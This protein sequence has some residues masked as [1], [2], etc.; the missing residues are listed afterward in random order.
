MQSFAAFE[1]LPLIP[2]PASGRL[3]PGELRLGA[4]CPI[5]SAAELTDLG[6]DLRDRLSQ[7]EG[8]GD[9]DGFIRLCLRPARNDSES[10][11]S[12]ELSVLPEGVEV[13][14]PSR[15]GIF[16][17]LQTLLQLIDASTEQGDYAGAPACCVLP[18]LEIEDA[19]RFAWRGMMLDVARH[20]FT[21]E[22]VKAFI[23]RMAR[24][25]FNVFHWHLTDDQGWRVE[26]KSRPE[27]T[28]TGAVRPSSP[29]PTNR[30]KSDE[31]VYGPFFYTQDEIRQVVEYA[32]QRSIMIVPE[33]DLPGHVVAALACYP[34]LGCTKGP[35]AVRT[36]WGVEDHVLCLGNP[37]SLDFVFDVLGEL[38][39]LFPGPFFHVGGDEVPVVQ[40]QE[41][42]CCQ[43]AA[44]AAGIAPVE[45]LRRLF[46]AEIERFLAA[47]GKRA[48]GWD[49][50]VA[51]DPSDRTLIAAWR[52]V[53]E[54]VK[55][56]A[57]GYEVIMCPHT[58]CYLDYPSSNKS[59]QILGSPHGF[60]TTLEDCYRFDPVDEIAPAQV[61]Q[62]VGLQANVWTEYMWS[63]ADVDEM[64]FPRAC[65]IAEIGWSPR[66]RRDFSGFERRLEAGEIGVQKKSE[67]LV[68]DLI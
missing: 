1:D 55:A 30:M 35:Y 5:D 41:C 37:A 62:V 4:D 59:G 48:V 26:I 10:E 33:I 50:V 39:G 11:E 66:A 54:G 9:N 31:T 8:S 22:E 38:T 51:D 42:A 16:R 17:G 56:A 57:Q 68:I 40:W 2:A 12:Y 63:A 44:A 21:V 60:V 13:N 7:L 43:G 23:D 64:A 46:V 20:F 18:C 14:A 6:A 32:S 27:L 53:E 45:G 3:L 36:T 25:K 52:S 49:E 29:Q 28:V 58:S 15:A 61:G 34:E 47:R 24:L 67:E 65:A 19:P